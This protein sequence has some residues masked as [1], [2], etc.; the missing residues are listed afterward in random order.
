M[1]ILPIFLS[2]ILS[3]I[4]VLKLSYAGEIKGKPKVVDGD[5][6]LI[7]TTKIRLHGID[8]PESKQYC[9]KADAT[10]YRCGQI[11]TFVLAEIIDKRRVTCKGEKID[12][13]KRRISIC[14]VGPFDINAEMVKRGWAVAYRQYSMDYVDEEEIAKNNKV[15]MWLGNFSKPWNWRK[16]YGKNC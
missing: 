10:E 15:G 1:K 14:Y 2:I 4:S 8:A 16:R 12:R 11:A 3:L 9:K 7:G 5:T 13:Y 6:I